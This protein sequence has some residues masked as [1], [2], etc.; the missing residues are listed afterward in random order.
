MQVGSPTACL[1]EAEE[2]FFVSA[3]TVVSVREIKIVVAI[4]KHEYKKK[5]IACVSPVSIFVGTAYNFCDL[6]YII[7]GRGSSVSRARDSW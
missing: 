2:F 3:Y 4:F 5:T 7:G 6:R 1:F